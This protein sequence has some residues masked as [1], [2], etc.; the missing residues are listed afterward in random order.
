M[1]GNVV[2]KMGT[3]LKLRKKDKMAIYESN[4]L[5]Y[6]IALHHRNIMVGKSNVLNTCVQIIGINY[7]F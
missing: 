7:I 5:F 4:N 2:F 3:L 1:L 6:I